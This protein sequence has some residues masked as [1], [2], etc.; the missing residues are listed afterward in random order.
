MLLKLYKK[1]CKNMIPTTE[2]GSSIQNPF[3]FYV[4]M[5]GIL[6]IIG[7]YLRL[8]IPFLKKYFI[9]ASLVAGLIGLILGPYFLGVIPKHI[10]SCWSGMSGVLIVIVF[11]PMLMG[12]K[13]RRPKELIKKVVSAV[14][15]TYLNCLVQYAIPLLLI[16]LIFVPLGVNQMFGC[17]IEEG[18]AGGHGTASGMIAVYEEIGW[19]DGQS[20]AITTAT[21]G[22]LF[23]IFGGVVLINIAVRKGWTACLSTSDQDKTHG[24]TNNDTELYTDEHPADTGRSISPMVIDNLAFHAAILCIAVFFGYIFNWLLKTFLHFSVSWFV[25]ALFAG[26][27]LQ[28]VLDHTQWADAID[29]RVMARLQGIALEF[30]VAGAVASVNVT[31]VL[32]YALPLIVT[33]AVL[34]VVTVFLHTWYARRAFGKYWF[35]NAML[36]FG[37]NTGVAATGMLLLKVVDPEVKSDALDVFAG[38]APFTSWATGGGIITSTAP[39]WVA[40][41]GAMRVAV[42]MLIGAVVF[43]LIPVVTRCWY[44]VVKD[45]SKS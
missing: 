12:K 38:R 19:P 45:G 22:L 37:T 11:A 9:P 43:A 1:G 20:L 2:V 18:W 44:P 31:V 14:S 15:F 27:L 8:K 6:L 41:Y 33:Q 3:L 26:Y 42:V 10:T 23:G 16:A 5:L 17:T 28:K 34:M 13:E 32:D 35:E 36:Y 40:R 30:L 7:T 21:I 39:I 25:M 24:L 29:M 4:S